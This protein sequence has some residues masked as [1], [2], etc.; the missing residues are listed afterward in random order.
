MH[1][2]RCHN[3]YCEAQRKLVEIMCTL[4]IFMHRYIYVTTTMLR[5]FLQ[6]PNVSV[7]KISQFSSMSHTLCKST[8]LWKSIF[9][10]LRRAIL[11][12]AYFPNIFYLYNTRVKLA[13]RARRHSHFIYSFRIDSVFGKNI[14]V[15]YETQLNLKYSIATCLSLS[16]TVTR[17]GFAL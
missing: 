11:L 4:Q 7:D 5:D 15:V 3:W 12:C 1:V 9:Y 13:S 6:I 10:F 14:R 17:H 2:K 8:N 16:L